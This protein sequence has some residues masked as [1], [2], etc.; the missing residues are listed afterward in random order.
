M[1]LDGAGLL[2]GSGNDPFA[3]QLLDNN[4]QGR[5]LAGLPIV[6]S[7]LQSLE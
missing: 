6:T 7:L 3:G 5:S 2:V 1:V 4:L